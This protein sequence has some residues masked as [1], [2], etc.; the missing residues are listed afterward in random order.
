[1]T[2]ALTPDSDSNSETLIVLSKNLTLLKHFFLFV[3]VQLLISLHALRQL[4]IISPDE[5]ATIRGNLSTVRAKGPFFKVS[6]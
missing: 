2:L 1:M 4:L 5:Q 6:F 3:L